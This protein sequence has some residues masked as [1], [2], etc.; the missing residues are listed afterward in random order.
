MDID[1]LKRIFLSDPSDENLVRLTLAASRS[2]MIS[3]A[4]LSELW[5]VHERVDFADEQAGD[6][7][8]IF[9]DRDDAESFAINALAEYSN[10]YAEY[11]MLANALDIFNE[12]GE[13]RIYLYRMDFNGV[14]RWRF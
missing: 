14:D 4:A 7:I 1:R 6:Y 10:E 13:S 8:T 3:P 9:F 5:V 2:G 12:E 11:D